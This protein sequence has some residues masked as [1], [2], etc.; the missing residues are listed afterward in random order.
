M[1]VWYLLLVVFFL[2]VWTEYSAFRTK[3]PTV[4]SFP[5][6]RKLMVEELRQDA[7]GHKGP[8]P[9]RVIDLGSGNGQLSQKIARALP[10]ATVLGLEIS[11]VPYFI[12]WARQKL[13]GPANL[14]YKRVNFWPYDCSGCDAVT[15]F[16]TPAVIGRASD[17]LRRELKPGAIVLVNEE[18]LRGDWTPVKTLNTGFFDIKVRLYRQT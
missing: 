7:A 15:V 12:S 16:L 18:C 8:G 11:P 5:S 9:Y 10:D 2:I 14:A 4:A 1:I 13:F 17:K 3:V 6:T